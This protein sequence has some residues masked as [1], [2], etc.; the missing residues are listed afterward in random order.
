MVTSSGEADDAKGCKVS[1]ADRN[2]TDTRYHH[3]GDEFAADTGQKISEEPLGLRN[4]AGELGEKFA[5]GLL[6][7]IGQGQVAGLIEK[8][9]LK[10]LEQVERKDGADIPA[11]PLEHGDGQEDQGQLFEQG[12][13]RGPKTWGHLA[14]LQLLIVP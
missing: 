7:E 14:G 6:L 13:P 4:I 10:L 1:E 8:I 5:G 11:N 2:R 12:Q 9:G 3:C